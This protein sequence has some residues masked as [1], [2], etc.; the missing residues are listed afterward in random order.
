MEFTI[1][2]YILNFATSVCNS[3]ASLLND[4][5]E[6]V[7]S[8]MEASCSC[9]AAATPCVFMDIFPE[10]PVSCSTDAVNCCVLADICSVADDTSWTCS[11]TC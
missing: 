4:S 7:I 6:A 10:M 9:E 1:N 5:A 8:S 2:D 11:A 3:C